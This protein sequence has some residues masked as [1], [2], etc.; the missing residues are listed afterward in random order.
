MNKVYSQ[1]AV[2]ATEADM[3]RQAKLKSMFEPVSFVELSFVPKALLFANPQK[4]LDGLP[5]VSAIL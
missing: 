2:L 3:S 5:S 1:T 4:F